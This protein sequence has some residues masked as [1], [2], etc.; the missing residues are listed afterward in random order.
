M[1]RRKYTVAMA[2]VSLLLY[3][4]ASEPDQLIELAIFPVPEGDIVL[5]VSGNLDRV[6]GNSVAQFDMTMLTALPVIQLKTSTSVT[7][8]VS[9]FEGVLVRDVLKSLGAQG[10]IV[11]AIARNNYVIDIPFSDFERFDA[12]IAYRMDGEPMDNRDKGP[13][14]IVYPRDAHAQLQDIRYDYRWVWQLKALEIK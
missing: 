12:I 3:S 5:E 7:D 8:G 13:L 11:S 14:W 6:N 10:K 1:L 2:A 4:C 9:L